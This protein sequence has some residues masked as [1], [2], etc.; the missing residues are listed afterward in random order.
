VKKKILFFWLFL[1]GILSNAQVGINTI[2]PNP[3]AILHVDSSFG[4]GNFGGFMPPRVTLAERNLIPVTFADDGLMLY[5]TFPSGIR[6]LQL[7]NGASLTWEDVNCFGIPPVSGTVF[8]ESMGNVATNTT[9]S[10]HHANLGFDNSSTCTF[11]STSSTQTQVRITLP[12][13]AV[14]PT[15]SGGGNIFFSPN[16]NRNF[17]IDNI[18]VSAHTGPLTLKLLIHKSTTASNGSEL[19]IEYSTDGLTWTDISINDLPT[20]TGTVNWYERTLS[21]NIPNTISNLRFIRGATPPEFRIDD[22]EII[23]P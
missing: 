10:V 12:S 17:I 19:T 7:F 18:D 21:T 9:I 1:F 3:N 22:I 23:A 8:F 20:G 2:T 4:G 14:F 15:A 13:S 11:S 5:V 16:A 6:C